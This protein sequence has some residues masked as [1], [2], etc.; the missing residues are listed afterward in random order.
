MSPTTPHKPYERPIPGALLATFLCMLASSACSVSDES[1]DEDASTWMV[2]E[3]EAMRVVTPEDMGQEADQEVTP[4]DLGVLPDADAPDQAMEEPPKK[5]M[6]QEDILPPRACSGSPL[7]RL[8]VPSVLTD[9]LMR[10]RGTINDTRCSSIADGQEKH[11]ILKIHTEM[12]VDLWTTYQHGETDDFLPVLTLHDGCEFDEETIIAC[13]GGLRNSLDHRN[14]TIRRR[15]TPGE[16]LLTVDERVGGGFTRGEGGDFVLH[17]DEVELVAHGT[18]ESA[19]FLDI[20]R[21]GGFAIDLD[22]PVGDTGS[23]SSCFQGT[24][25]LYYEIEVPARTSV[26][27]RAAYMEGDIKPYL[28]MDNSCEREGSLCEQRRW[29]NGSGRVDLANPSDEAQR[30]ILAMDDRER[31]PFTLTFE[32][33][34]LAPNSMCEEAIALTSHVPGPEQ[35][36]LEAGETGPMCDTTDRRRPLFYK[37]EVPDQHRIYTYSIANHHGLRLLHR[38]GCDDLG[39]RCLPPDH[40]NRSGETKE[41]IIQ[42]NYD[43]QYEPGP[44]QVVSQVVPLAAH[45]ACTDA[46]E[47]EPGVPLENQDI[48]QGSEPFQACQVVMIDS[49][50]TL[51]YALSVPLGGGPYRVTATANDPTDLS[52]SLQ[53]VQDEDNP[54]LCHAGGCYAKD[55]AYFRGSSVATVDVEGSIGGG[56]N[57]GRAII[58][59]SMSP[60]VQPSRGVFSIKAEPLNQP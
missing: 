48:R 5:D 34:P 57:P 40:I 55:D 26:V 17:V 12:V 59:V 8:T 32:T 38:E 22:E 2:G 43:D 19:E 9:Q 31:A 23:E 25:M 49:Q 15:L 56:R 21:P 1:T 4:E 11:Y 3:D 44:V 6:N 46:I 28:R 39:A 60:G 41:V 50:P 30:Y 35:S 14:A 37:I 10:G 51:Y 42:A 13:G 47:L 58:A 20:S 29:V 16:Y 52:L 53:V 24:N 54:D 45:S 27:A 36:W 18:C 7:P 33:A